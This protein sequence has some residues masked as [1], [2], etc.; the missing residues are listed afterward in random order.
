MTVTDLYDA[1]AGGRITRGAF[2]RRLAGFGMSVAVAAAYADALAR[3]STARAEGPGS[4]Y[5][6]YYGFSDYHD[7]YAPYAL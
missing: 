2:I 1:Y 5:G 3:P 6:D 4:G 7:L